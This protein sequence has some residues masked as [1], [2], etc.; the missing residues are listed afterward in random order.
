MTKLRINT[1]DSGSFAAVNWLAVRS[2]WFHLAP[3]SSSLS[4]FALG[5]EREA[6][7]AAGRHSY[8]AMTTWKRKSVGMG[9]GVAMDEHH[10]MEISSDTMKKKAGT[11]HT[12]MP[13]S[14][15]A[16]V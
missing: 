15:A 7:T 6:V 9:V 16:D 14:D 2:I 10:K 3:S 5:R 1:G 12:T 11:S 4:Y 8:L 13:S